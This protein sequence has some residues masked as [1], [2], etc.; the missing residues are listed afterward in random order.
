MLAGV[1]ADSLHHDQASAADRSAR[2]LR[3]VDGDDDQLLVSFVVRHQGSH[4]LGSDHQQAVARLR[5]SLSSA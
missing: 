4:L 3:L 2:A 1:L 5:R